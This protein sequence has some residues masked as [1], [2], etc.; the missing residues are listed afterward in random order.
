MP[1]V[2]R[3]LLSI[4]PLST[5]DGSLST[6][7][8]LVDGLGRLSIDSESGLSLGNL[9]DLI[10]T[11]R[12]GAH[13]QSQVHLSLDISN[14][15]A[16]VAYIDITQRDGFKS[17]LFLHGDNILGEVVV[18][19][20][21]DV[22][23]VDLSTY[24]HVAI[25]TT[26]ANVLSWHRHSSDLCEVDLTYNGKFTGC[27]IFEQSIGN[28]D[29]Q[30]SV[31]DLADHLQRPCRIRLL[32]RHEA[33]LSSTGPPFGARPHEV[34][35]QS[36]ERFDMLVNEERQIGKFPFQHLL[37]EDGP[38]QKPTVVDLQEPIDPDFTARISFISVKEFFTIMIASATGL[39]D[40][41]FLEESVQVKGTGQL[42][43]LSTEK[44]NGLLGVLPLDLLPDKNCAKGTKISIDFTE[45]SQFSEDGFPSSFNGVV[46]DNPPGINCLK[47]R[48]VKL[49]GKPDEK[50]Q[51]TF[52]TRLQAMDI[53]SA[54]KIS[55]DGGFG[56]YF[57]DTDHFDLALDVCPD[58]TSAD[59]RRDALEILRSR[60]IYPPPSSPEVFLRHLLCGGRLDQVPKLDALQD[61]ESAHIETA[62]RGMNPAQLQSISL[63][64]NM[65][66]NIGLIAGPPG[67]GKSFIIKRIISMFANLHFTMDGS[68]FG[69][70]TFDRMRE[71]IPTDGYRATC[72]VMVTAPVN[73]VLNDLTK[74]IYAELLKIKKHPV[75]VRPL[76]SRVECKPDITTND[77][78]PIEHQYG[79]RAMVNIKNTQDM[80]TKFDRK[81]LSNPATTTANATIRLEGSDKEISI[82]LFA[83]S[84]PFHIYTAIG[85]AIPNSLIKHLYVDSLFYGPLRR[86]VAGK[87][88]ESFS[89]TYQA[90]LNPGPILTD[91]EDYEKALNEIYDDVHELVIKH[92]D[93]CLVTLAHSLDP[94]LQT[95]LRPRIIL[96]DEAAKA[97]PDETLPLLSAYSSA[98]ATVLV[99]DE[100]QLKPHLQFPPSTIPY[101]HQLALSEF[102]RLRL[103]GVPC[104]QLTEQHRSV[105]LINDL[106]N[107]MYNGILHPV[108]S[109]LNLPGAAKFA[110]HA[111]HLFRSSKAVVLL[112]LNNSETRIRG[113]SS[114]NPSAGRAVR[115][116]VDSLLFPSHPGLQR[117]TAKEIAI[118]SPYLAQN[119]D[120]K[121]DLAALAASR[122]DPSVEDVFVGTFD[123]AQ[124]RQ[125]DVVFCDLVV[126]RGLGFVREL[127]RLNVGLSRARFGLVVV[128]DTKG[129]E[130]AVRGHYLER[131][132]RW[133]K[134]E[135]TVV[136]M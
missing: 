123:G 11:Q 49:R 50:G 129:L 8:D 54:T 134:R 108:P 114:Y 106:V 78:A 99:G 22:N 95:T 35:V 69:K 71:G 62:C 131:L 59:R 45:S 57:A 82:D 32:L 9:N 27:R 97:R 74:S 14:T 122:R 51:E 79:C 124:G 44:S 3:G 25:Q 110:A 1:Q 102:E 91:I 132:F 88:G 81:L 94:K 128:A 116:A 67:C 119:S 96:V 111:R 10:Q 85:L 2:F 113:S 121:D 72:P 15:H 17:Q 98:H 19:P 92:A 37:Q 77:F 64:R 12:T 13:D 68:R 24:P 31:Q 133:L 105:P 29:T 28:I 136:R 104:G 34:P 5:A 83:H 115:D 70:N 86:Y 18:R 47:F 76:A 89:S 43:D 4:Q 125:F 58:T 26:N 53:R 6:G 20:I 36:F 61:L 127:G 40:R 39:A 38:R 16:T 30:Q 66:G 101:G 135:G 107:L 56:P 100:K 52:S 120:Y 41:E 75:I 84:M 118:L 117:Y 65:T 109:T 103:L 48:C 80:I 21:D 7:Q 112:D 33:S 55:K 42:I 90:L 63:L 73:R 23:H 126:S 130:G 93:V 87:Y 46:I 60:V